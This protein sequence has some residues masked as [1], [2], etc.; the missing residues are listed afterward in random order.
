MTVEINGIADLKEHVGKHLGYSGWFKVTQEQINQFADAT[1]DHQW[2][3]VDTKAA[4]AGPYGS[5]I[6]H[7]YLVLSLIPKLLHEVLSLNQ[8]G[9]AVN[10]GANKIRFPG[11][12]P[13]NSNIR[14]GAIIAQLDEFQGG[15]QLTVEV[16][17]EVENSPKPSLAAQLLYRYYQ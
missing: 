10:Y 16:T 15:L 1:G 12:V 4:A 8:T 3:H 13:A 11:P 14:L 2:I 5:T 17:I 6:A 7:G 9:I